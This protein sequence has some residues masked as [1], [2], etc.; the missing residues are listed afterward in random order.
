MPHE[1]SPGPKPNILIF[2]VTGELNYHDMT[3]D[4][5]LGLNQGRPLYVLMDGSK[6]QVGL[7]ENFLEGAKNSFFINPNLVHMALYLESQLLRTIANMVA[8]VTRRREKLSLHP[9]FDAAIQ[10]LLDLD[11]KNP[12]SDTG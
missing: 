3:C 10:H 12:S 4:E 2:R 6:M 8:K 11:A 1:I 7:P 5:E 9:S